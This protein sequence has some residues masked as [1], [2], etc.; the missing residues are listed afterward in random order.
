MAPTT[1][2]KLEPTSSQLLLSDLHD[3]SRAAGRHAP[4][5]T[6]R[7]LF[8]QAAAVPEGRQ[9]VEADLPVRAE[10]SAPMTELQQ[11]LSLFVGD[12]AAGVVAREAALTQLVMLVADS[13]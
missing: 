11:V 13:M 8:G 9:L 5:A 7:N 4:A 2:I 1:K 6:Q 3:A 12:C 10:T